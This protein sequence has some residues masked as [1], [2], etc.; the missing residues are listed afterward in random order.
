MKF[1]VGGER[2]FA[3]TGSAPFDATKPAVLFIHGAGMDHSVWVM[4]TRYFAR[5]GFGVLAPDFPAHGRSGGNALTSISAMARWLVD[6]LD[7]LDVEQTAVVGHSMGSLVAHS[8]ARLYPD[9][10]RA[11]ALL[12]TS[13]PM[14]VT[15][16]LLNAAED[17]DHA[18][19]D[20]ANGWSHSARGKLGGNQNPGLWMLRGGERLL[21]KSAPGV[22][23]TD[24]KACNEFAASE[25]EVVR[26]P[27]LVIV[28]EADQMTP[29]RAGI[30]VAD[31]LPDATIVRL[32]G[33]GHAMMSERPN[34]VLDAL[35]QIV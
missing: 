26:C 4:P 12:G 15:D 17:N 28:G 8:F 22:F 29:V 2:V 30:S 25:G 11:L 20:M 1:E 35:I 13:A 10:C 34:D 23:H 3:A 5:H 31:T 6:V 32:A 19:I 14:P 18:A 33:C 21:E 9:R 27:S 7:G 16:L 24:L